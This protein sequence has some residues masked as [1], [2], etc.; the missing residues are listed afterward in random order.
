MKVLVLMGGESAEREVSL[1]SGH[2]IVEALKA[3]GHEV[4]ALDI[5]RSTEALEGDPDKIPDHVGSQPPDPALLPQRQGDST[6]ERFRHPLLREVDIV[7]LAL[8]GGSGE[9]GTVQALLDLLKVP[10]N[11]SGVLASALCMDKSISKTIFQ[12]VGVPTPPWISVP[13]DAD[14]QSLAGE[15]TASFGFPVVVKPNAQGS[16]VGF[17]IVESEDELPSALE[18]A[19][20]YDHQALV[21]KFIPGREMTVAILGEEALPVVEIRPKHGVYDYECK[22]T[23]GMSEYVVPAEIPDNVREKLQGYALLAFHA[24]KCDGYARVDFRLDPDNRP[25]CLEVNT[26]PGMTATSLVPKAA[27]AVGMEF[28]ELVERIL[29]LALKKHDRS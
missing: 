13:K 29:R 25:Y 12:Q 18:H 14:P 22:Y 27:R 4:W 15:I 28:P 24:L 1:A 8:H 10:Y 17:S 19:F 16:T 21:E 3:R 6:L 2:S 20:R 11:G 9:N 23:K 5:G 26:L 7:F